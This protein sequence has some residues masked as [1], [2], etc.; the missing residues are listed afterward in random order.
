MA[1][2]RDGP[3]NR[4]QREMA[5]S[6]H[7]SAELLLTVINDIL[8]FSKMEAEKMSL[9]P[10]A[11]DP[12]DMVNE[13]VRAASYSHSMGKSQGLG[14]GQAGGGGDGGAGDSASNGGV[15]DGKNTSPGAI[16]AILKDIDLPPL[17]VYG[18]PVRPHQVLGNLIGNSLKSGFA[19]EPASL[20]NLDNGNLR[21]TTDFRSVYATVLEQW[22]GA[23]A[24]ELLGAKF[25]R[26]QLFAS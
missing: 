22:L 13:V 20:T 18:D 24:D 10:I 19:G 6:V 7:F 5:E 12:R 11:F 21:Y 4:E 1:L 8:D 16:V 17:L 14:K 2:L 15:G 23:P 3:L 25:P 26:L 9:H